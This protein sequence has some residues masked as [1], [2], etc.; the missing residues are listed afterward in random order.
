[1]ARRTEPAGT[2]APLSGRGLLLATATAALDAGESV[3]LTGE[4]G[5]GRSTLAAALAAGRPGSL[6]L[7]CAPAEGE[8]H[9]PFLGLIDLLSAVGDDDFAALS[10][11][12]RSLLRAALHRSPG[13]SRTAYGDVLALRMAVLKTLTALCD[14]SPVLLVLDDVQ[15]LDRPSA[16]AL[17]FVARRAT[18]LRLCVIATLRTPYDPADG[19]GE[20]VWPTPVRE[21]AVPAMTGRELGAM[22]DGYAWPRPVLARLHAACGGNPY[23][24]V[25]LAQALAE[26]H[27]ACGRD[28][29]GPLPVPAALRRQLLARLD[30]LGP[31]ARRTLLVASAA[32]RPTVALL[33]RAGCDSA[34]DDVG[35]AVRWGLVAPSPTGAVRF[36]Q[37]L[38][39]RVVYEDADDQARRDAHAALAEAAGDPVERAHHLASLAP[40]RDAETAAVLTSAAAT[41]RR[42]GAPALAARLG[43]LAAERTP[44]EHHAADADRR[45]T[46][47]ED[48]VAAGDYPLARGL[49]HEVLGESV[50]PADRVR[51]WIVLLDSCGQAMAEVADVFP[52]ALHDARGEPELLARLHYRLSWRAWVV[53]GS[54]VAALTHAARSAVLARRAGDRRTELLALTQQSA[55]EFYLGR[56]GAERTLAR[57]LAAPQDPRVLFDHNGPVF[58]KHR[59]HLLHDRLDDARTELRALAYTV[60]YRGSAESLCQCLSG[61]AQVEILRG[62]CEAALDLA[63][64]ALRVTEQAGLSQGPAWYAVALAEAAGGGADRALAA[65]ERARRHS[66]DDDDQLFLPRA[67][68]AEGHVRLL[69]GESAAAVHALQ[70]VRLLETGQGQGDP[71]VRRWQPDLA[72]A[73]VEA[74]CV[75]EAAELLARTRAMAA[76]LGRRGLLAVLER[77]AALVTEAR[78]EPAR[79]AAQLVEAAGRLAGLPYRLEEAR[80]YLALGRLHLRRGDAA[81]ARGALAEAARL[82]ARAGARPWSAATAAA[83]ARLDLPAPAAPAGLDALSVTERRVALLVAQGASNREIAARLAVSV[84]TVEAALTRAYRKLAVRSRVSLARA[85]MAGVG[86]AP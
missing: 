47:A 15:W 35:A 76:R 63:H 40:G 31:R 21:L 61:L 26:Q 62:R 86:A 78:G 13:E 17:A 44:L 12:E 28:P 56:P 52:Q 58:L 20:A 72:E 8:R 51:A 36:T 30:P 70:R 69:R 43:R 3:L 64:Q 55:L 33:R 14:R 50:R 6:V 57:A 23:V 77:P 66:E 59:R 53:E 29:S 7:R 25:E 38:M 65:A 45:L 74:G 2:D 68:H 82:F 85:V 42:R 41:A 46:A 19:G 48:A 37:P 18:R 5:I 11:R 73:L 60:R 83:L 84:K 16:Q 22:L 54:A 1:M 32:V 49:A 71:A 10:V 81:Q 4:P 75:D 34:A 80:T 27:R 79:A 24:A 67:L 9:L 39:P